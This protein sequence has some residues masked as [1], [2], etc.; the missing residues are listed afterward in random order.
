M[1]KKPKKYNFIKVMQSVISALLGV[2]SHRNMEKD[3]TTG[4]I[5]H[6]VITGVVVLLLILIGLFLIVKLIST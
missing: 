1:D 5:H 6:Y 3:F 2:Q 4:R